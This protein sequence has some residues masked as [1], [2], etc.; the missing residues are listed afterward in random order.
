M[1]ELL[2]ERDEARREADEALRLHVREAL[3]EQLADL[4]PGTTVLVFGSLTRPHGFHSQSDIDLALESEPPGITRYGLTSELM[5]RM[6]R[7]ADI[8][9]LS[10]SR[11]ADKIRRKGE[12]WT[13]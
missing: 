2:Q 9:L 12:T 1:L 10:E 5:E 6:G 8:I 4:L 3:R 11:L 7:P 13:V